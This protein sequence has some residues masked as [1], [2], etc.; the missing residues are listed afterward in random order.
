MGKTLIITAG[1]VKGFLALGGVF[2]LKV[3]NEYNNFDKFCGVSVGSI[4]ATLLAINLDYSEL[5]TESLEFDFFDNFLKL[6]SN[7]NILELLGKMRQKKIKGLGILDPSKIQER[8]EYWMIV[9]YRKKLT[10]ADLYNYTGNTLTIV[11]TDRTNNDEPKPIYLNWKTAPTYSI[12]KAVVE[13]CSVPGVFELE[14]PNRIDGV[15]SDPFPYEVAGSDPAVAFILQEDLRTPEESNLA[16]VLLNIYSATLIP[17]K[18]ILKEKIAKCPNNVEI[19]QL[20]KVV[21]G[22]ELPIPF[23]MS[24]NDKIKMI[25]SGF[26]QASEQLKKEDEQ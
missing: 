4:L 17:I 5:L 3:N 10:F 18:L 8:I 15:F 9:K 11:V 16:E 2:A 12:A 25:V 1:G 22:I 23:K 6:F 20:R 19:I 21:K 13:S 26:R 24:R 14:N 7:F